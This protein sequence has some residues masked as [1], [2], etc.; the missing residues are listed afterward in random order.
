MGK[1]LDGNKQEERPFKGEGTR[2]KSNNEQSMQHGEWETN[3]PQGESG[4][5][6]D[7]TFGNGEGKT[8]TLYLID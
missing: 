6:G 2:A 4:G 5:G 3:V 7:Q 1:D 8:C